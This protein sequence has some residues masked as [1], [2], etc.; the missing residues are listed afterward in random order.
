MSR[1]PRL[2]RAFTLIEASLAII[3]VGTGCVA[4]AELFGAVTQ[5][6]REARRLT[7]ASGLAR[8]LEESMAHLPYDD[9]ITRGANFGAEPDESS[10][11]AFDDL[12]DFH[13][14]DTADLGA[15]VDALR[16]AIPE[17]SQYS[18]RVTVTRVDG[19]SLAEPGTGALRVDV[20]VLWQPNAATEAREVTRTSWYRTP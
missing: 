10:L 12:D 14:L 20:V 1:R 3:I 13:G 4:A 5:S 11:A 2:R 8:H 9:P 18:Q 17:L 6:N 19:R 16:L 7:V 15:P